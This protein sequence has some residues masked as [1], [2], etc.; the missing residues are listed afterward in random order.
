M[1]KAVILLSGGLD[2]STLLH[3]VKKKLGYAR[4]DAIT[5]RYGQKHSREIDCA[6][7]Q[8][9]K[10]PVQEHRVVDII[11]VGTLLTG[12]S[13]LTDA[14]IPVPDFNK[15]SADRLDQPS[16]YV[17]HRNMILLALAAAYAEAQG[18]ADIFYGAQQQDR[19]GYW[20]CTPEFLDRMNAVLSL[21]RRQAV[22]LQA[23]F[24]RM[25]KR[26]IIET[27]HTLGVDYSH[28]WTCYRGKS[29]ACGTCPACGERLAAFRR[30]G[31]CDPLDY[32]N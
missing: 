24:I 19:Y 9:Q 22:G 27:G 16:T 25:S 6:L 17:P 13:A 29:K 3:Y 26:D 11:G 7:W 15:I 20:D 2:S 23:P 18:V 14:G 31:L 4:L 10:L 21:N 32:D 28:T 8:A 30:L 1:D 12:A 5:F